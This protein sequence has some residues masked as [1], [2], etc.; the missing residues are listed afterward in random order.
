MKKMLLAAFLVSSISVHAQV[1]DPM[2]TG[3]WFNTTGNMYNGILTDVEAV[4]YDASNVYVKTSGIPHYYQDGQS[5]NNGSDLNATWVLPRT[6]TPSG[7]PTGIQGGQNGL[8]IDGSVSFTPGDAQSYNNAGVW[9]RLAYYFEYNDVD[10]SNGHSTPNNV[11]H[12]HFDN[13]MLH[14]WDSTAHSPIVGYSWDGYP[15]YGP[16]GYV[17]TNG[18]GGITRMKTSYQKYTYTTRTNGP[19]VNAQYP[20]GCFIEDWHYV[21]GSGDLDEHNGRFC[22]TPEYPSGTYAYFTTV[23]TAL[24]PVYPYFIGPTF[25]GTYTN[26]NIGPSG[27]SAT[28]PGTATQYN[29]STYAEQI[30]KITE[31]I[32]V[33]P[34]PVVNSLTIELTKPDNYLVNLYNLKGEIIQTRNISATDKLNMRNLAH[35][36]YFIEVKDLNTNSGFVQRI[37]KQ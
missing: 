11:Y 29:P 23:D 22:I 32:S 9:N 27:G 25:Y 3:W 17:N 28:V 21:A 4:F 26:T 15:V 35:G 7:S 18:T 30:A 36:I 24:N 8:M 16:F 5:V 37:V 12:H 34:V 31:G 6:Q 20:I 33:Y 2:I 14:T 13:L 10:P 19:N 1:T